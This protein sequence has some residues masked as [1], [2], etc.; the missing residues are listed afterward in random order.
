[1]QIESLLKDYVIRIQ[2]LECEPLQ[3]QKLKFPSVPSSRLVSS[4]SSNNYGNNMSRLDF[5]SP[6]IDGQI[7]LPTCKTFIIIVYI[8][9]PYSLNS[10]TFTFFFFV[11][12]MKNVHKQLCMQV[13][14]LVKPRLLWWPKIIFANS[15]KSFPFTIKKCNEFLQPLLMYDINFHATCFYVGELALHYIFLFKINKCVQFCNV[16]L[17]G[18]H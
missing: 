9:I 3:I 2:E 8:V 15:Y 16:F 6:C 18:S 10:K 12:F 1:M 13:I 4:Y 7:F 14:L 5:E 11:Y 17:I